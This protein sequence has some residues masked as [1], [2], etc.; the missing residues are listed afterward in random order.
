MGEGRDWWV[1][2]RWLAREGGAS[3]IERGT[4]TGGSDQ[5][6]LVLASD[7]DVGLYIFRYTGP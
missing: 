5:H 3:L 2:I 4:C 7:R 1:L 6:P